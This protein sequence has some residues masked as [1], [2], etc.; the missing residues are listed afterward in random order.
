MLRGSFGSWLGTPVAAP[1]SV[2]SELLSNRSHSLS[3]ERA[4]VGQ[5]A[6]EKAAVAA[7]DH[8]VVSVTIPPKGSGRGL[9]IAWDNAVI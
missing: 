8:N 2:S 3:P 9:S 4:A 6:T 1:A 7:R 5:A